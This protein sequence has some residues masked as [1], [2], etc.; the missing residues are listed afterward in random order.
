[1]LHFTLKFCQ[2]RLEGY[3]ICLCSQCERAYNSHGFMRV[4]LTLINLHEA[5]VCQVTLNGNNQNEL[6]FF[7]LSLSL[8]WVLILL[9]YFFPQ[10]YLLCHKAVYCCHYYQGNSR[11]RNSVPLC[12]IT[13]DKNA[14][15]LVFLF[16]Y[17]PYLSLI[18]HFMLSNHLHLSGILTLLWVK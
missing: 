18:I 10:L 1:M 15:F 12:S 5:I 8:S 9:F 4:I 16:F 11:I 3:S 17:Y 14:G 2:F 7:S 13:Q 6:F